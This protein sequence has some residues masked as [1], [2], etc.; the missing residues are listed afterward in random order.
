MY[1]TSHAGKQAKVRWQRQGTATV[2]VPGP[3]ISLGSRKSS[4]L[5]CHHQC[6]A[7]DPM[8][9]KNNFMQVYNSDEAYN[10]TDED[11]D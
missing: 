2:P 3:A 6:A 7:S 11:D 5:L 1:R 10:L 4:L 8:A 9:T